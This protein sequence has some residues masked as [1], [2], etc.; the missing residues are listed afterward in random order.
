MAAEKSGGWLGDLLGQVSSEIE[1]EA[2]R[3]FGGVQLDVSVGS[4]GSRADFRLGE[5][6]WLSLGAL[7]AVG[8]VGY[9]IGRK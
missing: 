9:L 5:K 3:V 8:A 4:D 1:R 7:V 2:K 6:R